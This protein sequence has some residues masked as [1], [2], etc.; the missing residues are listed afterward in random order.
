M[1]K[2]LL[3][4]V[5]DGVQIFFILIVSFL[6]SAFFTG[7][8]TMDVNKDSLTLK[9][10][11]ET[12]ANEILNSIPEGSRIAILDFSSMSNQ[13]S[14][15][16][17]EELSTV[18]I[19]GKKLAV[20]ERERLDII[21]KEIEFQYSGT[22]S[23]E[24]MQTI[25][26]MLGAEYVLSGSIVDAGT[27]YRFRVNTVHIQTAVKAISIALDVDKKDTRII[28][29]MKNVEITS[30][31]DN[32]EKPKEIEDDKTAIIGIWG[33][34][35]MKIVFT[36]DL[37]IEFERVENF[38]Q[39]ISGEHYSIT[40]KV[41]NDSYEPRYEFS[42]SGVN[43]YLKS[44]YS[45]EIQLKKENVPVSRFEGRWFEGGRYMVFF[46]NVAYF[47]NARYAFDAACLFE[48]TDKIIN[49]KLEKNSDDFSD[50]QLLP[51]EQLKI[52]IDGQLLQFQKV[53]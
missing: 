29:F 51:N 27:S 22:V 42:L 43:L 6:L 46:G 21:K 44:V 10:A 53:R 50:Y 49:F 7:C 13:L 19:Q 25:G 15:F 8:S 39:C 5:S 52:N 31:T 45:D 18:L 2:S 38:W 3:K 23:D 14:E 34:N 30:N 17:I 36:N 20:V 47:I 48:Y 1:N 16:I 37:M 35:D 28:S 26:K 41:I 24:S 32:I 12:S 11:I 4:R 40:E 9:R 33:N